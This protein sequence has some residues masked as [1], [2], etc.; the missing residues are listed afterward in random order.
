M[1]MQET[2]ILQF[3][4]VSN[5]KINLHPQAIDGENGEARLSLG[6]SNVVNGHRIPWPDQVGSF[7]VHQVGLHTAS[8]APPAHSGF[9]CFDEN[10][11]GWIQI[12][13]EEDPNE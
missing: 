13:E 2:E 11:D 6:D 1:L 12:K 10:H 4:I 5:G 7:A 8:E 3:W 9:S